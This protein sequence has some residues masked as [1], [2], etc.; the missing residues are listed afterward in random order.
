[1]SEAVRSL[2]LA[3]LEDGI[4]LQQLLRQDPAYLAA[5]EQAGGVIA[6]ALESD[7]K[8]L[9][10]GNGGSAADAQHLAAEFTGRFLV[11]RRPLAALAL[12]VNTS[13]LTAIGNDYCFETVFARQVQA[14][15]RRGDVAVGISTSGNSANV[16]R[17]LEAARGIGMTTV[18]IGGRSGKLAEAVDTCVCVPSDCTPRIQEVHIFTGH[19]LCEIV[20]TR[21]FGG[22][23]VLTSKP[24]KAVLAKQ[25]G[26]IDGSE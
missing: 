21:L 7:G 11:E 19:L 14:L 20:E 4:A 3:R 23:A 12:T 24:A 6:E 16:L 2:I 1:M 17:A 26:R 18:G 15:G 9:F 10:F 8:V 13:S 5:V 22:P 25:A